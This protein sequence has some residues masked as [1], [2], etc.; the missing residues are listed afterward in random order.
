MII[1]YKYGKNN[2]LYMGDAE[3][4]A[5]YRVQKSLTD[6]DIVKVAH[7]GDKCTMSEKTAELIDAEYA[8]ISCA[9]DNIYSHPA[10][11]TLEAYK[12]SEILR[13]YNE[14]ISFIL[15]KNKV[16]RR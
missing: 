6:C 5:Q 14:N 4:K 1:N 11:E 13:T 8:I 12:N 7:H 2:I 15:N 3:E 10:D 9:K 16:I